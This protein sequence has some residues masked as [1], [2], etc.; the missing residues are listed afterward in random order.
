MQTADVNQMVLNARFNGFHLW[1]L[2]LCT[3]L[4]MCDGY[5]LFMYG[6]IVPSLMNEWH[7]SPIVVG[8]LNSY[9]LI[10]MMM[11]ALTFSPVAD[12]VGRKHIIGLS[13]IVFC[14]FTGLAGFASGPVM[15]GVL[16]FLAGIG[17]GGIMPNAVA[18]VTE[19]SPR[20]LRSTL[21]AFM[22]CGHPLG[23]VVAALV[24]MAVVP[25][26]GWRAMLWIGALP[27]LVIP[28]FYIVVPES[29][30]FLVQKGRHASVEQVV[31]KLTRGRVSVQSHEYV[32][33]EEARRGF[34]V[35]KLFQDGRAFSTIMFWISFF[36]CLLT[37][38]GLTT[39]LPQLMAK[40]GFPLGPSLA[41]LFALNLGAIA[42][43]IL[44]GRLADRY[45][46]KRVIVISFFIGFVSIFLMAF[47]PPMFLLY[48]LLCVAG[49]TTI[50]TQVTSNAYVSQ[51]YPQ[52]MRSTGIGWSLGIGRLGGILGPTIG[53]LL[54]AKNLPLLV[55]FFA[56]ALPS[57][58]SALAMMLVQHRY[59]YG[60]SPSSE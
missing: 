33:T 12:K 31:Y 35:R 40:A 39:W 9:T 15:F 60:G 45:G 55:N 3:F 48:L 51:F 34:P 6:T 44:G 17:L 36:M 54:V 46:A 21:V 50:G 57:L 8:T 28:L 56:F 42:G 43:G 38:Y 27:L 52:E 49:G 32:L 24:G 7:V 23:G 19:Y 59:A 2:S 37:M 18:L 41:S 22:F 29:L 13:A 5:D 58:V 20:A 26:V 14:T 4:I 47:K 10:G 30:A 1:I 53:G 25:Q 11:G 16:R